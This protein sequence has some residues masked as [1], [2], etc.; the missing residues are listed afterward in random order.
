VTPSLADL[1][2]SHR[3]ALLRFVERE[4]SNLLRHETTEDLVQGI[5]LRALEAERH[6]EWRG[7]KE[8]LGWLAAVARQHFADRHA[9]WTALRRR[10]GKM[11]R[12]SALATGTDAGPA[13]APPR[14][15]GPGPATLAERRD[16]LV[17]AARAIE[18]LYPRDRDLVR[19]IVEDEPLSDLARRLGVGYE[20]AKKAR[21]RALTR[22]RKAIELLAQGPGDTRGSEAAT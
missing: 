20:A 7:E 2:Q 22:F 5:H 13:E 9:Y 18:V 12:L 11:L 14:S 15:P 16:L 1:L 8:F 17:R 19:A 10:A 3:D 21:L 6:F 4:A